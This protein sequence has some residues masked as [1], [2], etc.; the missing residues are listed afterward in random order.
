M[1]I[2][3][4]ILIIKKMRNHRYINDVYNSIISFNNRE[5][6]NDIDEMITDNNFNNNINIYLANI[7]NLL[8]SYLDLI[9]NN[10]NYNEITLIRLKN[11]IKTN[12]LRII[13][14][15]DGRRCCDKL[16]CY[17]LI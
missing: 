17:N 16:A 10:N 2:I 1:I 8:N 3:F 12:L 6:I 11:S 5:Y 4:F 7:S 14:Y 15:P 9:S 13:E